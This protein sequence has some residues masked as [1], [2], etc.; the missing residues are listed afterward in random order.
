MIW[1]GIDPGLAIIGWAILSGD[2]T[3]LPEIIEYGI[4]ETSK[5]ITTGERLAEIE[6][7]FVS[8]IN[9]FQPEGIAIEMPF[10]NRQIKAAGGVLQALGV[11][12]LVCFR[13]AHLTPIFLHQS[14]WKAHLGNGRAKKAEIASTLQQ[15]FDLPD[16]P[17]D[18]SVDAIAIAYSA[19]CGLR[20]M[21]D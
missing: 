13:D 20:N 15:L 18:D 9:E 14:S 3:C 19:C 10:F 11:I 6:T 17:I 21:I 1:L 16:L 7:D 2:E 12:N 5:N 8:I 4:I